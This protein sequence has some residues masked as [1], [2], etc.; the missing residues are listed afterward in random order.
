MRLDRLRL[1]F[2][3]GRCRCGL[4]PGLGGGT[5][6]NEGTG[7]GCRQIRIEGLEVFFAQIGTADQHGA[8]GEEYIGLGLVAVIVSE[9]VLE[10]GNVGDP[11]D[12]LQALLFL[13]LQEAAEH[14]RL[15]I[16]E[17]GEG[18]DLAPAQIR[19]ARRGTRDERGHG[20]LDLERDIVVEVDPGF[21]LHLHAHI[22]VAVGG[23]LNIRTGRAGGGGAGAR[24]AEGSD[25]G[26]GRGDLLA[27][28]D[29]GRFSRDHAHVG[30]G[31]Q[32]GV[33]AALE[34]IQGEVREEEGDIRFM[35][36]DTSLL[37]VSRVLLIDGA[38]EPEETLAAAYALGRA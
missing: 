14:R 34:S 36:I 15:A 11:P 16:F 21:H 24:G 32:L 18:L 31:H 29:L 3:S 23:L 20:R 12:S 10:N 27:D 5:L 30:T 37:L 35:D 6:G 22:L 26:L 25:G 13:V 28:V 9:E 7:L 4:R 19:P 2:R 8:D 17:P 33:S 1:C 38:A